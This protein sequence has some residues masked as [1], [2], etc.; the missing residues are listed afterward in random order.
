MELNQLFIFQATHSVFIVAQVM[1]FCEWLS[2]IARS[3]MGSDLDCNAIN[4]VSELG[5]DF[6]TVM[7]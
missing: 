1:S 7:R 4:T 3:E 5:S 6:M 2:I